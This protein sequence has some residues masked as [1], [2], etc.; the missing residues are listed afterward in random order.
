[1]KKVIFTVF[2]IV[3][4]TINTSAFCKP[5]KVKCKKP[6]YFFENVQKDTLFDELDRSV[7]EKKYELEKMYPELGFISVKYFH[8][9]KAKPVSLLIK[10]FGNDAYLFINI[11]KNNTSLEK[12]IY[13]NLKKLSKNSYLINDD[14]FCKQL[15]QDAESIRGRKKVLM[16][17]TH[18]NPDMYII[19]MKRYVGYDKKTYFKSK[20]KRK[21]KDKT[22]KKLKKKV[23]I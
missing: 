17:D 9:E 7:Q 11:D 4:T 16:H 18:Y 5:K 13:A 1:M 10:Q 15:T 3:L 19:D 2:L 23:K 12:H 8:K 22:K 20:F 6:I 14:M 21:V